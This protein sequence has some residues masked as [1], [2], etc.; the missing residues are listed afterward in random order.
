M[1]N[2]GQTDNQTLVLPDSIPPVILS[3]DS[4]PYGHVD[5]IPRKSFAPF[6]ANIENCQVVEPSFQ[7]SSLTPKTLANN[8]GIGLMFIL[9]FVVVAMAFRRG[10]ILVFQI[11]R[12]L[13]DVKE[14]C[15]IFVSSTVNETQLRVSLL[16][17]LFFAEGIFLYHFIGNFFSGNIEISAFLSVI[18]LA[19]A[20]SL[21]YFMQIFLFHLL[22]YVFSCRTE[23]G[24]LIENFISV[25]AL[26]G[27]VL[28][29]IALLYVYIVPLSG[30]WLICAAICYILA[31]IIFIYKVVKIFLRDISG[32]LYFILYLCA[33]E[34]APLFLLYRGALFCYHFIV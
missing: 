32:L 29:P 5:T 23:I 24:L 13:F 19:V 22:G 2:N 26:L 14:R 18:T 28:F 15:S 12:Y 34:I 20:A 6:Q 3:P 9:L 8:D 10:Y 11:I 16:C 31:R 33:L 17:T 30:L 7:R 1:Q 27:I 21:F 4:L 25:N